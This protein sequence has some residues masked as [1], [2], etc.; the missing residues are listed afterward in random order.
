MRKSIHSKA[1]TAL[2]KILREARRDAGLSQQDVADR[3]E[4]PQSFVAKYEIGER[5]L[6][7]IEFVMVARAIDA[8]PA[9]LLK[10]LLTKGC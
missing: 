10:A 1:Q 8:D 4:K 3:L 7:V 2:R 9:K 5:R 6:D